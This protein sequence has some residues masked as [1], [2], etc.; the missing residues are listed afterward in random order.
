MANHISVVIPQDS[1]TYIHWDADGVETV[2]PSEAEDIP[3]VVEELKN[4]QRAYFDK[5]GRCYSGL[6]ATTTH[7]V[8]KGTFVVPSHLPAHLRQ[9]DLFANEGVYPV[10]CRY[11]TSEQSA[12]GR[13]RDDDDYVVSCTI[14]TLEQYNTTTTILCP[15]YITRY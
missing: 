10:A 12:P 3:A 14:P 11:F 2:P 1:R 15:L 9:S 5:T 13:D 7:E 6:H 4:I 8:V